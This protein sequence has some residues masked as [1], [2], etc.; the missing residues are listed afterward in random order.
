MLRA[1]EGEDLGRLG[2]LDLHES[3]V[4]LSLPRVDLVSAF[5]ELEADHGR[6]FLALPDFLAAGQIG[7]LGREAERLR[8]SG[9]RDGG[10]EVITE[11][12]SYDLLAYSQDGGPWVSAQQE[13]AFVLLAEAT[14]VKV[15]AAATGSADA[16]F[17]CADFTIEAPPP[18]SVSGTIPVGTVRSRLNLARTLLKERLRPILEEDS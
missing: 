12:E 18:G 8:A 2:R 13:T 9:E 6:G 7:E 4:D 14:P 3:A 15:C 5:L 11:E 17:A 10:G 1:P 16:V